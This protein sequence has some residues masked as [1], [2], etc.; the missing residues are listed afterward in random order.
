[1]PL[2]WNTEKVKDSETVTTKR[3]KKGK[4]ILTEDGKEQWSPIT[5]ALVE[6]TQSIGIS[7][8]TKKNYQEF[9]RRMFIMDAIYGG[10]IN[11]LE[12]NDIRISMTTVSPS[13]NDV[14]AHIGMWTNA[15]N[16][17]QTEFRNIVKKRIA[18]KSESNPDHR[19]IWNT[20]PHRPKNDYPKGFFS[21]LFEDF[22][23]YK[24]AGLT[25]EQQAAVT[26]LI[27]RAS[28]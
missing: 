4:P 7:K 8:I 5:M 10:C 3:D 19:W 23:K 18:E 2:T 24:Y 14:K 17:T 13:L 6:M 26:K 20:V 21:L 27:L 25:E 11:V 15:P 22:L 12:N 1:M 16:R 28:S 9:Y